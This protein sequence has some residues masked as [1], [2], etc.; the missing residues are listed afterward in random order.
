[1]AW[2]QVLVLS[3]VQGITE[4]LPISSSA[5]L[6]VVPELTGWMNQGILFDLSVHLGTL[7]AVMLYFKADTLRIIEGIKYTI[8]GRPAHP[9]SLLFIKLAIATLPLLVCAAL[10]KDIIEND[11]RGILPIALASI[12]FGLLLW[13]ADKKP[14]GKTHVSFKNALIFGLFQALALIPGTSRSGI[15]MT[16]GRFLG[17]SRIES[18]HFSMLMAIPVIGILTALAL[19]SA[20]T[21]D[22]LVSNHASAIQLAAGAALSFITAYIAIGLLMRFVDCIGFVPFVIYRAILGIFLLGWLYL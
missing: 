12:G 7:F 11:L 2:L 14:S 15:T 21:G 18:A 10:L 8:L 20:L 5:H 22:D 6:I 13:L 17:M 1:M 19:L 3:I 4:F 16:A 9:S